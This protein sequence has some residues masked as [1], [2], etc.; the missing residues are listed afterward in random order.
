[1]LMVDVTVCC[2]L[3]SAWRPWTLPDICIA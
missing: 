1:M 2:L 3:Q